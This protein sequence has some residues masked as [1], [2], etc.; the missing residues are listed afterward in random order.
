MFCPNCG[1]ASP[2]ASN[3]CVKCGT[4]L[5]ETSGRDEMAATTGAAGNGRAAR[6]SGAAAVYAGFWRRVGGYVI[7][8]LVWVSAAF[9]LGFAFAGSDEGA[10]TLLM[11]LVYFV[12]TWLYSALL[13]S[14]PHQATWGKRAMAIKV[15]T[16]TGERI[17][18]ARATGRYFAEWITGLTVGIGYVIAAFTK[19]RQT[20]HD[21]VAGT[22]VVH[23]EVD[24][25]RLQA[26]PVA[27]PASGWAIAAAILA[28][29]IVP[30]GGILAAIAIPA[31]QDYTIRS[32]VV[33]GLNLA[34]PYK[35]AVGEALAMNG[36]RFAE[37]SSESVDV[38]DDFSGKYVEDVE[39][40]Q[41][42]VAI[43]YGRAAHAAV[44]GRTL[45]LVPAVNGEAVTWVCGYGDA[46]V[47]YEVPFENHAQYTDVPEKYLPVVCR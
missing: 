6:D 33:E 46:P 23:R 14:G 32:Q 40:V 19:R 20:V 38:T 10:A 34:A 21:M 27:P 4:A 29:A 37:V 7:D 2:D 1:T 36:G 12:G 16:L 47:G 5:H 26:A 44:K 18:F 39:V 25:V 3:Y 31:Y 30:V 45:V 42:A 15:T 43:R 22:L 17:S 13:E 24:A 28:G 9:L 41:G 11:L 35:A 8:Y